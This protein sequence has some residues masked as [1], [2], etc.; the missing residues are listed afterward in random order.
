MG[1]GVGRITRCGHPDEVPHSAARRPTTHLNDEEPSVRR[2]TTALVTALLAAGGVAAAAPAASAAGP[3]VPRDLTITV[4]NLGPEHRPCHID[5]DLYV[6]AGVTAAH[7]A[8]AILA[9]NGFG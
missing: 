6:P 3:I 5:A 1:D 9:T 2:A 7:R 4:T 8:P